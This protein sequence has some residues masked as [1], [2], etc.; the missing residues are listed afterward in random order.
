MKKFMFIYTGFVTP[1]EEIGKA[2]GDWFS[3]IG[4]KFVDTGNPFMS[5]MEITAD[6]KETDL[7][8]DLQSITGYS[9]INATDMDEA[10]ALARTNPSITSIRVYEM[11]AM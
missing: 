7:P 10:K 6:G 1:T 5:G 3:S 11:G 4:D 9:I 2:W 8:L